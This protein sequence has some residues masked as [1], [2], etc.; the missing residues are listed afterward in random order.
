MV[1]QWIN[2]TQAKRPVYASVVKSLEM[3]KNPKLMLLGAEDLSDT[4][5]FLPYVDTIDI[6]ER[7]K[8]TARSMWRNRGLLPTQLANRVMIHTLDIF[9][10]SYDSEQYDVH[11]LD[12]TWSDVSVIA[13][14][15]WLFGKCK[16]RFSVV[17][18]VHSCNRHTTSLP[19]LVQE[20]Q[21]QANLKG[22]R[23]VNIRDTGRYEST[24]ERRGDSWMYYLTLDCEKGTP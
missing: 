12:T 10:Y 13:H 15:G 14:M 5:L 4:K 21:S 16:D 2:N 8:T 3:Y 23:V 18:E 1:R 20:L 6:Y 9:K 22:I 7:N 17:L 11:F 24:Q 19:Y